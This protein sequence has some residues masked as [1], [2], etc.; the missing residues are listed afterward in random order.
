MLPLS[1]VL[2]T[3]VQLQIDVLVE[4]E[5]YSTKLL[6]A[7]Y[8]GILSFEINSLSI[9]NAEGQSV[10]TFVSNAVNTFLIQCL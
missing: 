4:K 8:D 9:D 6:D 10:K 7:T 2:S 3:Y 5:N 1:V